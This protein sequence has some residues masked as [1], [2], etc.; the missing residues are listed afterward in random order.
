MAQQPPRTR[1][2]Q[3]MQ[4]KHLTLREFIATFH[5]V[6][7]RAGKPTHV[8]DRQAKRWISGTSD[9]PRADARR[10]LE[11]WWGEPVATLLSPPSLEV[12]SVTTNP[13]EMVMAAGRESVEHAIQAASALDPSALE[14]LHAEAQRA[15]RAYYVTPP[16][17]LLGD[18]VRLR[19]TVYRQL[20]RTHKPRQQAELY[21]IAGQVCGLLSSV[22]WDLGHP[23]VAEEQARAAHTY[24]S[25]I[26]HSSLQAWARALQV[27][28]TF[29]SGR[30]R[31]AAALAAAA[32]DTAPDGTA[33]ARLHSVHARALALLGARQEVAVALALA[34]EELDR[35]GQDPFLDETG[36][37]LGFDRSR[38]ALCAGAAYVS[39]AD[40]ERAEAEATAAL[41][42]FVTTPAASKWAAGALSARVDLGAARTIRGDLAGAEDA[43]AEVFA[44]DPEYRT[45]ALNLRLLNLGHML[46]GTRFRGAVEAGRL[47]ERIEDF[48]ALSPARSSTRPAITNGG[49]RSSP[50][51]P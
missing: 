47:G 41:N 50:V 26:E 17:H 49:Y 38:R 46:G 27:T 2:E 25:V 45:E 12:E 44:L 33:R 51:M 24:G 21:L 34:D 5:E 15:A 20:D 23:D 42:L 43:L 18:L 28:I 29:W 8:S 22:S 16:L 1:L 9:A 3:R 35:A 10:V 7:K 6:S 40:G 37:E 48:A 19:N 11:R 36:G 32:L 39:L 4:E 31:Q 30:P 13:K 14:Q